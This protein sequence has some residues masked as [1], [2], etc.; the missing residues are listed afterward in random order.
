MKN[1]WKSFLTRQLTLFHLNQFHASLL[2]WT[3]WTVHR[4]R[5]K[6]ISTYPNAL[7]FKKSI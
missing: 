2:K 1:L 4:T 7:K 6:L 3:P 5:K